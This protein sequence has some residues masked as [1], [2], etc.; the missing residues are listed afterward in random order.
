MPE[1]YDVIIIGAGASGMTAA[2]RAGENGLK[3]V[4]LE[5]KS[6]P[7]IKLSITGKGR[8]NLTNSAD[9]KE[10]VKCFKNG[11]FLYSAFR[12]FSNEDTISF[13]EKLGVACK[14]ERGGRYFPA[15]DK[16]SDI[17]DALIKY[18]KKNS[19]IETSCEV[20][21]VY[22]KE[23]IFIINDRFFAKNIIVACGGIAYPSTGSTGDGYKIARSFGHR[24]AK[25]L[26]AL[27]P[28]NL[29]SDG[30]KELKGLK[31]KNVEV[32]VID[33]DKAVSKEF[34]E[35]E[36]TA[37]GADGPVILTLSGMISEKI[38]D[39]KLF[40]SL[41]LKPALSREQLNQRLLRE[42]DNFG[43]YQLKDMLKELLPLQIIK[44]FID[45][46]GLAMTKK[47]S[48][49]NKIEREKILYALTDLRF[50]ISGVRDAK[51]AIIT[52]GGVLTDEID[53]KTMQSK[54]VK[55]LYFCGEVIDIDAPTG[56]FNLQ[57]AFSTGYLAGN[58][59]KQED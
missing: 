46:C 25:P 37:F 12:T 56:G 44:P 32:S 14:L 43:Q 59:I 20:Q 1:I 23:N 47:C 34:G 39:S 16:A 51:E 52:R 33:A 11:E 17:V 40:L 10:F 48:Q 13:F 24:I 58:S 27:V 36:F 49:I 29:K 4:I 19:S 26:P 57:A 30:L 42:L 3:S 15:S 22:K 18:A 45:H 54:I 21:S 55:G 41:N 53:Q 28:I 2:G 50:E 7:G 35:M 5:K 8:C 6:R 31:L 9:I 38:K